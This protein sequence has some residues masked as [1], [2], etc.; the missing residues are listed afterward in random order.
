M[1][2]PAK[3]EPVTGPVWATSGLGDG[4][5]TVAAVAVCWAEN[6]GVIV[7]SGLVW[8]TT[9][10]YEINVVDELVLP[11]GLIGPL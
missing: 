4:P 2:T 10:P 6:D 5:S 3:L 7:A 11:I 9:G 1:E 8:I